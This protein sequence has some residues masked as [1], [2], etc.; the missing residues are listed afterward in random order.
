MA[1]RSLVI[2]LALAAVFMAQ[3]PY[4]TLLNESEQYFFQNQ[5]P[6][7]GFF[8][9]DY[10][11]NRFDAFMAY[12]IGDRYPLSYQLAKAFIEQNYEQYP[13]SSIMAPDSGIYAWGPFYDVLAI[14]S[15]ND[16]SPI[17][18]TMEKVIL[19]QWNSTGLHVGTNHVYLYPNS[20]YD[21]MASL[22]ALEIAAKSKRVDGNLDDSKLLSVL[23]PNF[24][25]ALIGYLRSP[26]VDIVTYDT[27][28]N[29]LIIVALGYPYYRKQICETLND[30]YFDVI[31]DHY[32]NATP[33]T[34]YGIHTLIA[35]GNAAMICAAYGYLNLTYAKEVEYWALISVLVRNGQF[36]IDD[37]FLQDSCRL[38]LNMKP[39]VF[40]VFM[41]DTWPGISE[42]K[43]VVTQIINV[44][45]TATSTKLVVQNH[46][47]TETLVKPYVVTSTEVIM[48]SAVRGSF[49][50]PALLALL[51]SKA[52][53]RRKSK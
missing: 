48:A 13:L 53:K 14:L 18:A 11:P 15:M 33:V 36:P 17:V 52:K 26:T 27:S 8:N 23:D 10:A 37:L 28:F 44:T 22:M 24:W 50:S 32:L 5:L 34:E 43:P 12:A 29:A 4:A 19:D 20:P 46:T 1:V 51:V 30:T 7:G 38:M 3:I 39:R 25:T 16:T 21:F 41:A 47:T 9:C 31:Y 42:K 40:S 2:A 45:V 6:C 49:A 35:L